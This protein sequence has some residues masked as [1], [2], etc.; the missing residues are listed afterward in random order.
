M[1]HPSSRR[2]EHA[3]L[4]L[5][6]SGLVLLAFNLRPAVADVGPI[7]DIL[8]TELPLGPAQQ[9]ILTSLPVLSFGVFAAV[10]PWVAARLGLHRTA[11]LLITIAALALWGRLLAPGSATFLAATLVVMAALGIGNVVAPTLVKRDFPGHSGLA[12]A[13]YTMALTL[14]VTAA[15]FTS[16]PLALAFDWRVAL[17][18]SAIAATVALLPWIP[19]AIHSRRGRTPVATRDAHIT[20]AHLVR[21][22]TGWLLAVLFACQGGMAFAIIGWLPTVYQAAGLDPVRAGAMVGLM[23]LVSVLLAFPIPAYL[24]RHPHTRWL[25]VAIGVLGLSGFAGLILAPA[26]LPEVWAVL[27]AVGLSSFPVFLWLL[28]SRSRTSQGT[29][30]L[31]GFTQSTGFLLA[32]P[33]PAVSRLLQVATGSWTAPI[34]AWAVL[35]IVVVVMAAAAMRG[36]HVE[37]ELKRPV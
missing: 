11:A 3:P 18:P 32:A 7:L 21:T 35:L 13:S 31:S 23:N 16:A 10:G 1:P 17:M 37:D 25:Q 29:A 34:L 30:A 19:L 27:I 6:F 9:S 14:G 20:V 15:S 4:W 22:R 28:S 24:S 26:A 12:T 8:G 5:V 2:A 36:G 33:I